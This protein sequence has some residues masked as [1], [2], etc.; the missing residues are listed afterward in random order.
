MPAYV[1]GRLLRA[2]P[3]LLGLSILVFT[4]IHAAPGG[5][6]TV[7]LSNPNVRPEDIARLE[8]LLGL[9]RPLHEQYVSWLSAFLRGDWGFSYVDGRPVLDRILERAPATLELMGTSF[10]LALVLAVALGSLAALSPGGLLDGF[11]SGT[12]VVGI[13]LPTFWLGLVLQLVFALELRWLPTSGRSDAGGGGMSL[14]HL[15]LP[16]STLAFFYASSWIRY[17][18][19]SLRATLALDFVRAGRARGLSETRLLLHH[20]LPNAL[21]PLITVLALD[22]ALLFSGAV[23]TE[24]VFAWPGMGTLLVDSVYRRDY[25]VLMGILLS[26]S[27]AIV[28]ANLAADVAYGFLDPRVRVVKETKA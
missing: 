16:A 5:P 23:V 11:V 18:R 19:T 2:V 24:T 15:V 3:L 27:A 7:Y 17:V 25:S 12:S 21:F 6:L 10:A 13:S 8:R 9:D 14:S 26:G 4:L 22:L 1:F 28:L 20:S